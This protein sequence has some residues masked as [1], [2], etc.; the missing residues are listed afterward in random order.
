ML[1]TITDK[2]T[3]TYGLFPHHMQANLRL[4]QQIFVLLALKPGRL[5]YGI[6]LKSL[7]V[8]KALF[9]HVSIFK[10]FCNR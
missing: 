4:Q 2:Y 10:T 8:M 3:S 5:W 7:L 1:L 9:A 6:F